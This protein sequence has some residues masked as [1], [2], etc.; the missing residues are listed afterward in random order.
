MA[1]PEFLGAS[2][3]IATQN[4]PFFNCMM[5]L[6]LPNLSINAKPFVDIQMGGLADTYANWIGV[7]AH[8]VVTGVVPSQ[9]ITSAGSPFFYK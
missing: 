4:A 8:I 7:I 3:L 5:S 9:L 6:A 2:Q 1:G